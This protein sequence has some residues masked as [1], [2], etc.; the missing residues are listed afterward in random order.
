[1][2]FELE[3]VTSDAT[4]KAEYF[5]PLS[6]GRYLLASISTNEDLD[7]QA[8]GKFYFDKQSAIQLSM[9]EDKVSNLAYS[10]FIN[11]DYKLAV[12][13]TYPFESHRLYNLSLTGYF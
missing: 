5:T 10:K 13:L 11:D 12:G 2:S 6:N 9:F 8:T 1:M 3:D 7:V 4:F